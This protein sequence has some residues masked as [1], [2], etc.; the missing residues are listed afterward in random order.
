MR[1]PGT[2]VDQP[3]KV[4][5][6]QEDR[7]VA[8]TPRNLKPEFVDRVILLNG[9][10]SVEDCSERSQLLERGVG[11]SSLREAIIAM[12]NRALE[13]AAAQ[14][15]TSSDDYEG[16]SEMKEEFLLPLGQFPDDLK[17][18]KLQYTE[19]CD[20]GEQRYKGYTRDVPEEL[21]LERYWDYGALAE[22]LD[23]LDA[24][25]LQE[26]VDDV[27]AWIDNNP[28]FHRHEDE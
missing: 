9:Y 2:R 6:G 4:P 28:A 12:K 26:V 13:A 19:R 20:F 3:K 11:F 27:N 21:D 25:F 7:T 17:I 10:R 22:H 14:Q 1:R 5:P 15:G 24:V 18:G 16:W 8:S 23:E